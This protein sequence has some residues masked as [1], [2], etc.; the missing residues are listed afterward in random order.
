MILL[1][2]NFDSFTYNLWHYLLQLNEEC[3]VKRNDEITIKEIEKLNPKAIVLSPGPGRPA[4]SGVMN[5]VIKHFHKTTPL[6]GICLGHQAL[7]EFFGAKLLHADKPMHGKTSELL[8]QKHFLF[9]NMPSPLMVMRYHSL[10]LKETEHTP[11]KIIATAKSGADEEDQ[12]EHEIM[13]IEHPDY[14]IIGLQFHPESILTP[15]GMMILTN[16]WRWIEEE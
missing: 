13:A 12:Q 4:D 14:K 2:D 8:F 11:L 10:V 9:K 1:L 7:G 6:L 15:D 5:E 3:I 16:W